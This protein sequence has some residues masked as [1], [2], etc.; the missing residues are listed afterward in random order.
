MHECIV[1]LL[2][3]FKSVVIE[4]DNYFLLSTGS[5]DRTFSFSFCL[6]N[7]LI[8]LYEEMT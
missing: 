5:Q 2:H 4:K 1:Y 8:T 7:N 3:V 6:L